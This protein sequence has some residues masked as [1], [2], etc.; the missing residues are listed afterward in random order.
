MPSK[1]HSYFIQT[2]KVCEKLRYIKILVKG[3]KSTWE[4][5]W[6]VCHIWLAGGR[7]Q[8]QA[9]MNRLMNIVFPL[10]VENSYTD[11]DTSSF[12][13]SLLQRYLQWTMPQQNTLVVIINQC[14][15]PQGV[16]FPDNKW[17]RKKR[18]NRFERNLP[19]FSAI[20]SNSH[21]L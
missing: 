15:M 16:H 5:Y 9:L 10:K 19:D 6:D 13:R 14:H 21:F 11:R 18:Q 1:R 7:V 17:W 8:Q 2:R 3:S 20:N 12:T 4:M